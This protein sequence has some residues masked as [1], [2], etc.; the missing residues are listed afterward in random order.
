MIIWM[1]YCQIFNTEIAARTFLQTRKF[2]HKILI[3]KR[4]N[5]IFF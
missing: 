1:K 5:K 2:N 4:F 3:C